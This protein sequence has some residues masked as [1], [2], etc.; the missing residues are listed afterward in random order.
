MDKG[1][2]QAAQA[3]P[4]TV[5]QEMRLINEA[6]ALV[7]SGAAPRTTVAG[8]RLGSQLLDSAERLARQAGVRV[9]PLWRDDEAGLDLAVERVSP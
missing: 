8:L 3:V 2:D 1:S 7:A 9:V 4:A 5:D 6:I